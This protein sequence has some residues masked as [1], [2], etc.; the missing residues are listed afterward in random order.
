MKLYV[1]T[2]F[3]VGVMARAPPNDN[4][5]L[6]ELSRRMEQLEVE[7]QEVKSENSQLRSMLAIQQ[8]KTGKTASNDDD[9]ID[10]AINVKEENKDLK[11]RL[12]AE[13]TKVTRLSEKQKE[14]QKRMSNVERQVSADNDGTIA[15]N[16]DAEDIIR[17][18]ELLIKQLTAIQNETSKKCAFS[19]V[20]TRVMYGITGTPQTITYDIQHANK[21]KDFDIDT[22]IFTCEVPGIYYFSFTMRSYAGAYIGVNLVQRLAEDET[23]NDITSEVAM[24]TDPDNI[25]DEREIMQTQSVMLD[26]DIGD[27]VWLQLGP[28]DQFRIHS[29]S[30]KYITF[31]GF[32]LY[33]NYV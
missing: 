22:G 7:L 2:L 28:N 17:K 13:E 24:L 19:A 4:D 20:R 10:N 23:G 16:T 11:R 25:N 18:S 5:V 1:L 21:G 9:M 27:Q 12:N 6:A 33:P 15:R 3:L 26:L 32:I 29:N 8:T 31:N 14:L 30:Q